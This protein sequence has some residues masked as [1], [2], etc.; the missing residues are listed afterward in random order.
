MKLVAIWKLAQ[1]E[2]WSPCISA[3]HMQLPI[4][5]FILLINK[6]S[7]FTLRCACVQLFSILG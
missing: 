5:D 7:K 2:K 6:N 4:L 1:I 3:K